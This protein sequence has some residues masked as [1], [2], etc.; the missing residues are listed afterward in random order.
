MPPTTR[1]SNSAT[2]RGRHVPSDNLRAALYARVSTNDQTTE[3]QLVALRAFA[4]A[5]GWA[6]GEFV[7]HGLSG[8]KDRPPWGRLRTSLVIQ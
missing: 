7:D 4:S 3:D 5:R 6:P 1:I 8:T 2:R